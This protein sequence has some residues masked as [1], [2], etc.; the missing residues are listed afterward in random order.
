MEA[1]CMVDYDQRVAAKE[2]AE[3]LKEKLKQERD[4]QERARRRAKESGKKWRITPPE[5]IGSGDD[6]TDREVLVPTVGYHDY[7]G[8]WYFGLLTLT[9]REIARSRFAAGQPDMMHV[10]VDVEPK[11]IASG[12]HDIMVYGHK[13]RLYNWLAQGYHRGLVVLADD[14]LGNEAAA[15]YMESGTWSWVVSEEFASR[16]PEQEMFR[17]S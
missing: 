15:V 9:I 12:I 3:K 7:Y 5:S 8:V 13:C 2:L 4:E 17:L 1:I 14:Q 10:F 6:E 11:K 16:L